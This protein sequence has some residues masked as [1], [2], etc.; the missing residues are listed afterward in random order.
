M[1]PLHVLKLT[2]FEQVF[3]VFRR[4]L[5]RVRGSWCSGASVADSADANEVE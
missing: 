3:F 5:D 4:D 2:G 1:S